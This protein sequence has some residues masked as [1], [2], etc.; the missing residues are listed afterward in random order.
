MQ[1]CNSRKTLLM[2]VGPII[3]VL[4]VLPLGLCLGTLAGLLSDFGFTHMVQNI[5]LNPEMFARQY[6]P[7]IVFNG[8]ATAA[9][10]VASAAVVGVAWIRRRGGRDGPVDPK[11]Q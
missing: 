1:E 11:E 6:G 10:V 2:A 4:L 3:I 5:K 9:V 8:W 7:C